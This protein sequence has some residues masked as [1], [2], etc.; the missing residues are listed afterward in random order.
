[1]LGVEVHAS[2]D[3]IKAAYRK[4]AKELH[5]DVND[6]VSGRE[7]GHIGWRRWGFVCQHQV[8]IVLAACSGFKGHTAFDACGVEAFMVATCGLLPH[9]TSR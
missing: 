6:S 8:L 7:G 2:P 9:A 3:E 1:M 4:K 5:P